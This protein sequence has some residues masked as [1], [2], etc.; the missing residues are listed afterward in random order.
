MLAIVTSVYVYITQIVVLLR[1]TGSNN[2]ICLDIN[3]IHR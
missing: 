1:Y 2:A 3:T